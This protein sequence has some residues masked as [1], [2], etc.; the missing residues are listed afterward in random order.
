MDM[1]NLENKILETITELRHEYNACTARAVA[2]R[3]KMNPDT[4]RYRIN[5]LKKK[6]LVNW[7]DVPGSLVRTDGTLR[8]QQ[9][10]AA[11]LKL[12]HIPEVQQAIDTIYLAAPEP[13]HL[14][15]SDTSQ[16]VNV[17]T[18]Q[19]E[20]EA[21]ADLDGTELARTAKETTTASQP[22]PRTKTPKKRANAASA[23]K[24]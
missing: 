23:G 20:S 9:F 1:T 19:A 22:K 13:S 5:D 10:I 18:Q 7:H 15:E 2:S 4:M 11:I 24:S 17:E 8:D 6:G 16:T 12:N 21:T 3:L 14:D